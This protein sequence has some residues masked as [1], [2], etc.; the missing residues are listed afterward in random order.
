MIKSKPV[1][2]NNTSTNWIFVLTTALYF[3]IGVFCRCA[4]LS[5]KQQKSSG[6]LTGCWIPTNIKWG[7]SDSCTGDTCDIYRTASFITLCFDSAQ[8]FTY[9]TS[10]QR[11]PLNYNDSLIFEGE[12][13]IEIF[14]GRWQFNDTIVGVKYRLFYSGFVPQD[15]SL[16]HVE[17]KVYYGRDSLLL[18]DGELF[19]KTFKYDR[20]SRKTINRYK[21]EYYP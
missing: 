7:G 2:K 16:K 6:F 19:K 3:L 10:T 8:G 12:P 20:L 1:F 17:M 5:S 11:K 14:K 13:G 4:D 21:N 9:F 18:F 15:T